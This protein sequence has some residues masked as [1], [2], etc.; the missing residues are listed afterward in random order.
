M[1]FT[2]KF[3]LDD[4]GDGGAGDD[5]FEWASWSG[6]GWDM[7]RWWSRKKG[8]WEAHIIAVRAIR[9]QGLT[10]SFLCPAFSD[11]KVYYLFYIAN[12]SK[13][14]NVQTTLSS[15]IMLNINDFHRGTGLCC[16]SGTVANPPPST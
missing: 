6:S 14:Y 9:E 2:S 5:R 11:L 15:P 12:K 13:M 10:L 4:T 8:S 7:C 1:D 16:S 3:I